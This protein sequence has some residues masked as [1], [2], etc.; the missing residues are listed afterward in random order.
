MMGGTLSTHA[1]AHLRASTSLLTRPFAAAL[2]VMT[3]TT[4]WLSW[5]CPQ[6]TTA[7]SGMSNVEAL[8]S[9]ISR[10]VIPLPPA[11]GTGS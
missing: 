11:H 9:M 4:D 2:V 1:P 6:A 8:E 5:S 10:S 7:Q 3:A